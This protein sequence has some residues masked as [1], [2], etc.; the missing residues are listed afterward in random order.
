MN[1]IGRNETNNNRLTPLEQLLQCSSI[2]VD[3]PKS[4]S[5]VSSCS[6]HFSSCSSKVSA[7]AAAAAAEPSESARKQHSFDRWTPVESS[8]TQCVSK[9]GK[10][11]FAAMHNYPMTPSLLELCGPRRRSSW[12]MR[13]FDRW[14]PAEEDLDELPLKSSHTLPTMTVDDMNARLPRRQPS[15]C[16]EEDE[17]T[18]PVGSILSRVDWGEMGALF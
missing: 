8:P 4:H 14:S 1:T 10:A 9:L 16:A 17:T 3:N 6:C 15:L 11:A 18:T 12:P 2:V 13:D 7:A 5:T